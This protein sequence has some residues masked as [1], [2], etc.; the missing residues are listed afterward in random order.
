MFRVLGIYNF[1]PTHLILFTQLLNDP[2]AA[3]AVNYSAKREIFAVVNQPSNLGWL[4][5]ISGFS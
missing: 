3:A 2:L 1:A 5:K 4:A